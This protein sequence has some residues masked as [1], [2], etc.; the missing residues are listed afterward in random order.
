M[1]RNLNKSL[2]KRNPLSECF[3][4]PQNKKENLEQNEDK[5]PTI[6]EKLSYLKLY[7]EK[8]SKQLKQ[9]RLEQD[10][11]ISQYSRKNE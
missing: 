2:S 10:N 11:M 1:N 3:K 6:V 4:I 9:H 7:T 5:Q 8:Q